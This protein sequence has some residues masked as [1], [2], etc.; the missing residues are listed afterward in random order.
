MHKITQSSHLQYTQVNKKE[1]VELNP[2]LSFKYGLYYVLSDLKKNC[3][4]V[5]K[6]C[7][8]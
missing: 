1:T 6:F 3:F 2:K 8:K 4:F 7:K 5:L